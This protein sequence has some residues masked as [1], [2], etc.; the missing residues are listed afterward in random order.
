MIEENDWDHMTVGSIVEGLIEKVACKE[1][2]M[3]K[4]VMKPERLSD[5]QVCAEM[6]SASREL[7]ICEVMEFCLRVLDEKGM[8]DEW[9]ISG[10]VPIFK[11]KGDLRNCVQKSKS[12]RACYEDR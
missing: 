1:V 9:Q 2:V 12:V 7:G 6:I 11:E 3:A 8:P 4:K 5:P 10:L